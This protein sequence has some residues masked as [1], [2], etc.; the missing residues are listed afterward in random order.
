MYEEN[1]C[2][3]NLEGKRRKG[4]ALMKKQEVKHLMPRNKCD[5]STISDLMNLPKQELVPLLPKLLKFFED[6]NWPV[7][8]RLIPVVLRFPQNLIP[9]ILEALDERQTDYDYKYF[10]M[11]ALVRRI[12]KG[13][14]TKLVPALERMRDRATEG[15]KC[16]ELNV[17]AKEVLEQWEEEIKKE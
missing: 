16:E 8:K 15:E 4:G 3:G 1:K 9:L 12:S 5:E 6:L 2:R 7:T 14:Q 17:Y 11:S 10:V 13:E